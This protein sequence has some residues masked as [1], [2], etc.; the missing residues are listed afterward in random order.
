VQQRRIQYIQE[1]IK[2]KIGCQD[3]TQDKTITTELLKSKHHLFV[4]LF[5]SQHTEQIIPI[6]ATLRI[7]AYL[8]VLSAHEAKIRDP[9]IP[10]T[11]ITVPQYPASF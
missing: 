2:L 3:D 10:D 6:D 11:I 1:K 4:L 8:R 5:L 7:K 9:P